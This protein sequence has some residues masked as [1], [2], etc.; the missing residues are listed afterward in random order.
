[1][2]LLGIDD[3]VLEERK[4]VGLYIESL[5]SLIIDRYYDYILSNEKLA[6]SLEQVQ[7]PILKKLHNEMLVSL[8]NDDFNEVL[9]EKIA[10]SFNHIPF[11]LDSYIISSLFNIMQQTIIDIASVNSELSKNLKIILK[12]LHIAELVIKENIFSL[13]HSYKFARDSDYPPN[14]LKI[15]HIHLLQV[16]LANDQQ[17]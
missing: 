13:I 16:F 2:E 9:L 11:K 8:F 12:F 14:F 5:S 10:L 1:M 7:I 6:T 15:Q 17:A 4:G 3:T